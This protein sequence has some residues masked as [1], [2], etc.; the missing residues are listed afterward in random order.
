MLLGLFAVLPAGVAQPATPFA[1]P[2]P[3]VQQLKSISGAY[4]HLLQGSDGFIWIGSNKG[5]LRFDGVEM[6]AFRHDPDNDNSLSHDFI[7]GMVEDDAG[8]LWIVTYGGG[9]NRF[10]KSTFEFTHFKHHSNSPDSISSDRLFAIA[11]ANDN[12]LWLGANPGINLFDIKTGLSQAKNAALQPLKADNNQR[13]MTLFEDSKQ[14]LWYTVA[15]QG[16]FVY[17]S[18]VD[19]KEQSVRHFEHDSNDANSIDANVIKRVYETSQGDIWIAT[20]NGMN[21]FD[22]SNNSFDHFTLPLKAQN[23]IKAL[24]IRTIFEDDQQRLWVGTLYNGLSLFDRQRQVF[25]EVN[26]NSNSRTALT[27]MSVTSMTQDRSGALWLATLKQGLLKISS[28][29]FLFDV[30]TANNQSVL[31]LGAV[32]KDSRGDMWIGANNNLYQYNEQT[33]E[34]TLRAQSQGHINA[35]VEAQDGT[36][37]LSIFKQGIFKFE[38]NEQRLTALQPLPELP[39]NNLHTMAI[40]HQDTLWI[41]LFKSGKQKASGLF[42]LAVGASQY[43]HHIEEGVVASILPLDSQRLLLGFRHHGLKVYH[44]QRKQLTPISYQG[45]PLRGVWSLIKDSSGTIWVGTQNFGLGRFDPDTLAIQFTNQK[46]GLPS[47][48]IYAVTA[49]NQQNLWLATT[50][51][52]IRFNL[53]DKTSQVFGRLPLQMGNGIKMLTTTQGK[54]VL[55]DK[56][57]LT[58]FSP[59]ALF[60]DGTVDVG[61]AD[62][63]AGILLTDLK[64]LNQSIL[65]GPDSPLAVILNKTPHLRLSYQ[66]YLFSLSFASTNYNQGEKLRYAYKLEGLDDQ[67]IEKQTSDLVATFTALTP[68]TYEFKVKTSQLDGS[69]QTPYRSLKITITPPWWQTKLAYVFYLIIIVVGVYAIYRWKT[70]NLVKRS[71]ALEQ[72]I[73]QH[74]ATIST[75]LE[76]KEQLFAN[77]SHEFRTPLTLILSPLEQML[78]DPKSQHL[79]DDLTLMKRSSRRLLKLVDQLQEFTKLEASSAKSI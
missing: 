27:S 35:I 55:I 45:K 24:N 47:N 36:L 49:D 22:F 67:W 14:R 61:L 50:A 43:E 42:S 77:V 12:K 63:T 38:P 13:V 29:G 62:P 20:G 10:D 64:V 15:G 34:V 11:K 54:V 32:F 19:A 25:T 70:F 23:H 51:G 56:N 39:N 73:N 75:L 78:S 18:Q 3:I 46:D 2:G 60:Y 76:Q 69:W 72:G 58:Q 44:P 26:N 28:E 57:Q 21:R 8:M 74:T 52:L 30:L 37:R 31:T 68:K 79:K 33:L 17:D 65:P 1:N 53:K 66:D 40:D 71:Q 48:T 4:Y 5:L 7:T 41:S 59:L 6:K 16:L 9:L